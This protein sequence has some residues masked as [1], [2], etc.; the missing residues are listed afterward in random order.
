M[1]TGREAAF[2]ARPK[3]QAINR[4][5][6]L[7]NAAAVGAATLVT[8]LENVSALSVTPPQPRRSIPLVPPAETDPRPEVEVLTEGRSGS[9]FMVDII[10]SL[11]FEYICSN[12][13]SSFRGLQ[14]SLINYG[15]NRNPEFITCCHEESAVGMAHGYAKIEGKPLCVVCHAAVGSQ[16]AAMAIYNAYC[17]R[18]PVYLV[19]G[20]TLDATMRRPG[21]D[22]VHAVQDLAA[23]VRE[24]VKWD[25]MP[26][27]LPHFAQSAIRAYKIAMTPPMMPVLLVA[28]AELQENPVPDGVEL[29]IPKLTLTEPPQGDSGAVAEAAR[30]LVQAENPVIVADRAARTQAGMVSL[31]ELAELLQA[32]VIDQAGRMNFPSRHPLNQSQRAPALIRDADVILGL[33]LT[34][35]WGVVNSFRDQLHRT[36]HSDIKP[37]TKLISITTGDLYLKSNYQDSQRYTEVDIAIAADAEA[38]MPSLIEAVKRQI[39][40]DRKSAFQDRGAKLALARQEALE[41]ARTDATYG[42]DAIPISV[43]RLCAELWAQIKDE[44]WSLAT[45]TGWVLDWPMG[46]WPL[47]LWNFEKYYQYIGGSGAYGVGYNAPAAVGAALANRKYGRLTVNI[48]RDGDLLYAPSVLW[49]AAHHRIP[50]LNIMHNN[51][52]YFQEVMHVQR[53]CSRRNRGIDR[54]TIGT[55]ISDP[56]IDYAKLAQ[57][58]GV[59]AEGPISDPN[60]LGPA[61]RRAIAVVKRGDP[62]LVDVLTQPR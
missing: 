42:W 30:L 49:T 43:P 27:S 48:Q 8:P 54:A 56:N 26:V 45:E 16:H 61:I 20:N 47:R 34:D 52:A 9:D 55:T 19:F 12:P 17:D 4:R 58:Y 10:K 21:G 29:N 24:Y 15:G 7:K 22:Y 57:S 2:M 60:D 59:Y 1:E 50:I 14:E 46:G 38:T 51:R 39:T 28:D 36:S 11:G 32:P 41:Q 33:E 13:G 18:V 31:V 35:F 44:D 37:G 3:R 6:F 23:M 53:L 62:A 5:N 25:D 40:G